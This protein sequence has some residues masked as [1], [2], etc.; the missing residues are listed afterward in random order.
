MD[1][2]VQAKPK[3]AA[4]KRLKIAAAGG[5]P[6]SVDIG[7]PKFNGYEACR[8][9]RALPGGSM[10]TI[11]AITGW[12]QPGD[13]QISKEAGFDRHLVTPLDHAELKQVIAA[14]RENP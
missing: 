5:I 1:S 6:S 9:I 7:M 10:R 14:L 11:V 2:T 13:I 12:G 4:Q 3:K 8:H